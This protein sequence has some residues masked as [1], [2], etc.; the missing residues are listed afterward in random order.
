[1][2]KT[3]NFKYYWERGNDNVIVANL[4]TNTAHRVNRDNKKAFTAFGPDEWLDY[5]K[6]A[7]PFVFHIT[8]TQ[9]RQWF[10]SNTVPVKA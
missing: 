1:M 7:S 2:K 4:R 6:G 9:A 10:K 8:R 3:P 5:T